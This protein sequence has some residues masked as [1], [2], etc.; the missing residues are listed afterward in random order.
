MAIK[1][2]EFGEWGK[3]HNGDHVIHVTRWWRHGKQRRIDGGS[4]RCRWRSGREVS[5]RVWINPDPEGYFQ[6]ICN[7]GIP[8]WQGGIIL[9]LQSKCGHPIMINNTTPCKIVR[10][11]RQMAGGHFDRAVNS[12]H[13]TLIGEIY[14][15]LK[16]ISRCRAYCMY[17]IIDLSFWQAALKC[18]QWLSCFLNWL[19]FYG[20]R[21]Q[22]GGFAG[23]F[24]KMK[25]VFLAIGTWICKLHWSQTS[26]DIS[27]K[28]HRTFC[29][30]F[31]NLG[32][33][34]WEM[35]DWRPFY[36]GEK[37]S[38]ITKKYHFCVW[39]QISTLS[40]STSSKGFIVHRA[41]T[42]ANNISKNL[43]SHKMGFFLWQN[44]SW[45]GWDPKNFR[46]SGLP[47]RPVRRLLSFI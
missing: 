25:I 22:N 13:W 32:L 34:C 31:C 43:N 20:S 6:W 11:S 9:S 4:F 29:K 12:P 10:T 26:Y 16:L 39:S 33:V 44:P 23:K 19:W 2:S 7:F 27:F 8:S 42:V 40:R 30:I 36:S 5:A 47:M 24:P 38:I 14:F 37:K 35:V 1:S 21:F 15:E 3:C 17:F 45:V 28:E 46:P 41:Q 18:F